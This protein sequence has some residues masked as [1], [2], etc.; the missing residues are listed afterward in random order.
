MYYPFFIRLFYAITLAASLAGCTEKQIF[1]QAS[2]S[3]EPTIKR[4]EVITVDLDTYSRSEP[5]RW[6]VVVF[7]SPDG[8]GGH[9]VSRVVGLPE[10]TVDIRSGK[11][12]VDGREEPLP[13]RLTIRGY[14]LP[15]GDLVLDTPD[16]VAF[17]FKVPSGSFFVLGDNVSNAL[18]SRYLD[19]LDRSKIIGKVPSK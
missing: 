17:P 10:E 18:D 16:P 8:S 13:T 14:I 9:W 7:E 12:V 5:D 1:C 15:R 2:S 11:V 4:G 6:D 19:C 3:M